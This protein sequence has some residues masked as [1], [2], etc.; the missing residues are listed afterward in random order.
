MFSSAKSGAVLASC[1]ALLLA[2]CG[3]DEDSTTEAVSSTSEVRLSPEKQVEHVGNTWAPL[4]AK[5]VSAA[6]RYMFGQP[7]CEEF[8]GPVGAVVPEVR[9][10]SAFQ[11]SF[12]NATVER[13][14]IKGNKAGAEFSNGEP[15]EFIQE[16][17][18]RPPGL[19]GE[20]FIND[21]GGNAGK[22]YFEP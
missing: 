1:T 10:P 2:G 15:V 11:K 22:K 6:C 21:V 18:K 20:W 16:T 14:K 8:F 5:D 4:F 9:R 17:A 3:G 7:L 12:A 13:V 19:L